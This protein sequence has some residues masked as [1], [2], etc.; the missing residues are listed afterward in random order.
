MVSGNLL[1]IFFAVHKMSIGGWIIAMCFAFDPMVAGSVFCRAAVLYKGCRNT[2]S[3]RE[4]GRF[5]HIRSSVHSR[6]SIQMPKERFSTSYYLQSY[7]SC[8]ISA[9]TACS[10]LQHYMYVQSFVSR[11]SI[12]AEVRA[13]RSVGSQ[14]R[15]VI[16]HFI[17]SMQMWKVW[18]NARE[19]KNKREKKKRI[20]SCRG[21]T[22]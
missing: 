2:D 4:K 14:K 6:D 17:L 12:S 20:L 8:R 19:T 18:E 1:S 3:S 5:K 22:V 10:A 16:L 13:N 7:R 15:I 9:G 11:D 21:W